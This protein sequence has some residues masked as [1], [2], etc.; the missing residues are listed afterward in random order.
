M[1]KS[2]EVLFSS[3]KNF[4]HGPDGL[5]F[6]FYIHTLDI[7]CASPYKGVKNSFLTCKLLHIAKDIGISLVP[8]Q[9][10]RLKNGLR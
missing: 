5:M 1:L 4:F 10:N 6:E 7:T 2:K 3:S 9:H 8:K